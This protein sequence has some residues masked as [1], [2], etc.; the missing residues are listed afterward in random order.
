QP[1]N[2]IDIATDQTPGDIIRLAK[3][4]GLS[5]HPT[6]LEH[7]TVT[8][9]AGPKNARH[10]FE[11][12]TLR[13]DVETDGRRAKVAFTDDWS[14]DAHRRDFT[15]NA[16]Y[17]DEHGEIYD[18]VD[19]LEDLRCGRV[20]FVG[21][22]G[23]RIEEDHLR[24]LRFFRFYAWYGEGAP[25]ADALA[26]CVTARGALAKLSRE[27]IR[28]EVLKLLTAPKAGSTL[29]LM[30]KHKV[31]AA[32]LAGRIDLARFESVSAIEAAQSL[33]AD[34][35]RRLRAL[36]ADQTA[37]DLRA[38]FVLS[39]EET[40]RL[41]ALETLP[42]LSPAFRHAERQTLL[43]WHGSQAVIDRLLL[44]WSTSEQPAND[45]DYAALLDEAQVW[46]RP[47]L[48][49][50]GKD[51][52]AAGIVEGKELGRLLQ[53]PEDW[54]VAGGFAANKAELMARLAA[55]R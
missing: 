18:L 46:Q 3:S 6:G 52:Q 47:E 14:A 28:Q 48:P 21:S 44:D 29:S 1:I 40:K 34:P 15:F 55:I 24:I 2:D 30:H 11:V 41:A 49:I 23:E 50:G 8:M 53:A 17:C 4:A 54:W 31:L 26:A 33:A 12:T 25:D 27:R 19:G 7:G 9:V 45:A 10:S 20:R 42:R 37:Q 32:I 43:Y 16:L 13:V 22:P 38:A 36:S 39:N 5:V 35:V 51:L